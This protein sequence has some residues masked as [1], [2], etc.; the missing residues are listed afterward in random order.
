M[1]EFGVE[2]AQSH[3]NELTDISNAALVE[4]FF[5]AALDLKQIDWAQ[6]FLRAI[7]QL[8]PNNVK[9][10]RFLAM[11]YE[12]AANTFK[13]QEIYLEILENTPED[14]STMKRLISLYRNN[15]MPNDA[16]SMLNKY[17]EINQIDEEAWLE[18]CDIYLAKQNFTKAQ[19]CYEELLLVNPTNYQHNLKYAEILYSLAI[20]SNC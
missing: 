19:F 8:F 2:V 12:G 15:D 7:C 9:T 4:E 16:I 20:A 14:C 5:L 18:L 11:Y 1:L 13:A 6:V 10:M 3:P 17:L